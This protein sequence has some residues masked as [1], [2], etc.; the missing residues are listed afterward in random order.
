VDKCKFCGGPLKE[1]KITV[2][3]RWRDR[4]IKIKNVPASVCELCGENYVGY[5]MAKGIKSLER[6]MEREDFLKNPD[7]YMDPNNY[8][9]K[10]E[11][12]KDDL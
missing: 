10:S 8:F 1:D 12:F 6:P 11:D 2:N 4:N 9:S 5:D 3:A 7:L